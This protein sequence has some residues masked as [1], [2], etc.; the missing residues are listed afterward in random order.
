MSL[1]DPLSIKEQGTEENSMPTN[2]C[3][4]Y[5]NRVL[6]ILS[7]HFICPDSEISTTEYPLGQ[8]FIESYWFGY[9][10]N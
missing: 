6:I 9:F 3:D 7:V 8:Q 4:S 2:D 1:A 5:I 10:E